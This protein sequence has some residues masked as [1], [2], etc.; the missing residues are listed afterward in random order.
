MTFQ[1]GSALLDACTL[2][3]VNR[4][5]AYGYNLTRSL[6]NVIEVSE[7]ALYPVLRRLRS[8]NLLTVYDIPHDGRNRR[9]Y[10]VT[11]EGKAKL[12]EFVAEWEIFK[13]RVDT[14][15]TGGE[16]LKEINL[17]IESGGENLL[18]GGA[19]DE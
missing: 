6:K 8:D 12:A 17:E 13:E 4:G 2:A 18:E 5:D 14:I 1:V 16:G 7:S 10:R 19:D 9:Y 3:V 11:E 15:F